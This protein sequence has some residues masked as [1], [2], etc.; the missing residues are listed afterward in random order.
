MK[1]TKTTKTTKTTTKT[2]KN[3]MRKPKRSAPK[4]VQRYLVC[5]VCLVGLSACAEAISPPPEINDGAPEDTATT[6]DG[7]LVVDDASADTTATC[8]VF[9]TTGASPYCSGV[10]TIPAHYAYVN[11][12]Q[13]GCHPQAVTPLAC[14]CLETYSCDCLRAQGALGYDCTCESVGGELSVVCP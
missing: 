5:L 2:R 9:E 11:V 6:P 12:A 3:K 14:Q 10:Y 8:T 13:G 1:K 7:R 4:R